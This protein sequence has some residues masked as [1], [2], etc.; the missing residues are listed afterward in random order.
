M[1]TTET[2]LAGVRINAINRHL[3]TELPALG[4]PQCYLAAGCLFQT[5]WN[6]RS[7]AQPTAMI[8]DY[9]VLYFDD[10]DLA[11][12]AEDAVISKVSR[13]AGNLGVSVEVKNQARV[14]LWYKKRFGADYP[15]LDAATGGI[16]RYLIAC[17]CV[18]I[19]VASGDVYAPNGL[20]EMDRGLL[21]MNPRNPNPTL[22]RQKAED[23]VRR[24]PWLEIVEPG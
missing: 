14:H 13:I 22:F 12:E 7:N 6:L 19:D 8:K 10:S 3:L 1:L 2:F 16:D 24:W 5:I 15:K 9:D 18:G 17:T 4:L 11:W 23:Y 21:R 20:D